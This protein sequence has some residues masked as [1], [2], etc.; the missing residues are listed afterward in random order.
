MHNCNEAKIAGKILKNEVGAIGEGAA[1]AANGVIHVTP[2][3]VALPPGRVIPK[4]LVEN[5]YRSGSYGVME[6]G[7]FKETLR[8][9]PATA[10]GQAGPE[11][12]HYHLNGGKEHLAPGKNDPGFE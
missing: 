10:R 3:G 5:P 9:D 1:E 7:K 8:I 4:G 6:N 11:R 2:Q 12:S